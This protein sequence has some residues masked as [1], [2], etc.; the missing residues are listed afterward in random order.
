MNQEKEI[1]RKLREKL[2][3]QGMEKVEMYA[4]V[5]EVEYESSE[6]LFDSDFSWLIVKVIPP[7]KEF[8]VDGKYYAIAPF[9]LECLES[10]RD[11]LGLRQISSQKIRDLEM[12]LPRRG[13]YVKLEPTEV[14][15]ERLWCKIT[16]KTAIKAS[17]TTKEGEAWLELRAK[18][19]TLTG[20]TS[21]K[22]VE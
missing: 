2:A 20:T 19:L 8:F 4:L 6:G 17:R 16:L 18:E 9:R 11:S 21:F 13:V 22:E 3:I 10:A 5:D 1:R 15:E 12:Q 14:K 7:K